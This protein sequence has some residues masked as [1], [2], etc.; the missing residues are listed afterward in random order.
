LN[1]TCCTAVF[2]L[3]ARQ[4]SNWLNA[5]LKFTRIFTENQRSRSSR[6]NPKTEVEE[7]RKEENIDKTVNAILE[8]TKRN[9][10]M[11]S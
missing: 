2:D 7:I 9:F 10:R 1:E 11:V 5:Q 6:K 3:H 8:R 4:L